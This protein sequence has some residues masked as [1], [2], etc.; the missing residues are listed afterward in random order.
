MVCSLI[1]LIAGAIVGDGGSG[2]QRMYHP[3]GSQIKKLYRLVL[4]R[5]TCNSPGPTSQGS[6]VGIYFDGDKTG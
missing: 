2:E 1:L 5:S 4:R 6:W 3:N